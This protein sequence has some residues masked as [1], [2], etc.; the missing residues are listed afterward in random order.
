M[1][2]W[3]AIALL[4]VSSAGYWLFLSPYSQLFGHYPWRARTPARVVAL[5]FDDGPNEPYTSQIVEI[6]AG[7]GVRAT[8]FQVGRCVQRFPEATDRIH[9]AGHVIGNHS[10]TH[11]FST[12]L[13]PHR[14]EREV[15]QTQEILRQRLGKAP[16]LIRSPWL[17]RHPPLLRM[18]RRSRL[19]PVSGVFC[20]ALE[21]FQPDAAAIARRAVAK[22]TPGAILIFHDGF[23]SRGGNRAQTVRAV[24]LTVAAL[25]AMK[26]RF[27]TVDELLDVPAYQDIDPP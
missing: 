10:L 25:Q 13:W 27:V 19:H 1:I 11:R 15:R 9:A 6:L 22:V 14:Y 21:V 24:Q 3:V 12:Y 7:A 20:H 18:V 17:W 8:F 5:T 4:G 16:T 23:D 2:A 26:Y